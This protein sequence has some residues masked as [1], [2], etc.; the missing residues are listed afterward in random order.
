MSKIC[1]KDS[2]KCNCTEGFIGKECGVEKPC[3]SDNPCR[4]N[5][6][7][8][9]LDETSDKYQCLCDGEYYGKNCEIGRGKTSQEGNDPGPVLKKPVF[10]AVIATVVLLVLSVVAIAYLCFRRRKRR[11]GVA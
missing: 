7:C 6:T 3:Y 8:Q 11:V 2:F 9:P 5:G 4:N 10:I 1:E